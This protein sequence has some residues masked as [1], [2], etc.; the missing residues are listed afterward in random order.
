MS[1]RQPKVTVVIPTRERADVLAFALRTVTAQDY[2]R[3]EIVVSDNASHD[4]TRAV[5]EAVG[6]PRVRY[7]HTG[8]RLSMSE[9]WEFALRHAEGDWITI[10]GDDDGLMP[11]AIQRLLAIASE[12]GVRAIRSSVC[13]YE[14]P[15]LTGAG[16]GRLSIPL[17]AGY[18]VR[19]PRRWLARV[20][21]GACS[22]AELPI[23]Y[24]GGFVRREVLDSIRRA[25]QIYYSCIPDVYSAVA[26]CTVLDR[27]AYSHEPLAVSGASAHS[28]GAAYFARSGAPAAAP[29]TL[30]ETETP[31]PFHRDVP[32][33]VDGSFPKSIQIL[34]YECYLQTQALRAGD[35][36]DR[37]AEQLA[38]ILATA[39]AHGPAITAWGQQFAAMHSLDFETSVARAAWI[40]RRL[41]V[42]RIPGRVRGIVQRYEVGSAEQPLPDVVEATRVA[43]QI[44][45]AMPGPVARSVSAIA[46]ALRRRRQRAGI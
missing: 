38:V 8:R 17:G 23:L 44:R 14:W 43:A 12:T 29:L 45:A 32:R 27:F 46:R 36:V 19:D 31:I 9:N 24:N 40:R 20:M 13:K 7:I 41:E 1:E 25:G 5:V 6:D 22:Y 2:A 15:S 37:R 30:F 33:A 34:L 11:G 10:L 42:E 3:L 16:F 28:T 26:F 18:E 35:P 4:H 21:R 39:G